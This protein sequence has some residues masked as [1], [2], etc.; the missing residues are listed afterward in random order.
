MILDDEVFCFLDLWIVFS[1]TVLMMFEIN[2][3]DFYYTL[4]LKLE[5]LL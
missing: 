3:T 4:L 2:F 5:V 1:K